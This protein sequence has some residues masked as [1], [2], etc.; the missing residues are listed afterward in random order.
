MP[1]DRWA[2]VPATHPERRALVAAWVCRK[3]R[4]IA[5]ED[6]MPTAAR[7]LRRS[8]GVPLEIALRILGI[9]PTHR[10]QAPAEPTGTTAG[11]ARSFEAIPGSAGGGPGRL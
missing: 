5:E 2:L 9:T 4:L 6:G 11:R 10:V 7:R 8:E 1:R 3:Y